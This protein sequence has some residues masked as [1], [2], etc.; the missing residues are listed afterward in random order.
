VT[1]DPSV[2]QAS[3]E[4]QTANEGL[5]AELRRDALVEGA[6]GKS[7]TFCGRDG[8]VKA[9]PGLEIGS[10]WCAVCEDHFVRSP[11]WPPSLS[12]PSAQ[13]GTVSLEALEQLLKRHAL[14]PA[15]VAAKGETVAKYAERWLKSR[16]TK[17]NSIRDDRSRLRDHVLPVV[18][19]LD[20]ATFGRDDVENVRDALDAK[21]ATGALSW[22]T[23]RNVWGTFTK[24]CDDA[25]NVKARALRVRKDNPALGVKPPE[26][27]RVK[28][29]Q[30]LYPSECL[31]LVSCED[32]PFSWRRNA[33]VAIYSYLRDGEL[34]ELRWEDVD[35]EHATIAVSHAYNRRKKAS[36]VPKTQAGTRRVPIEPTLLPLLRAMHDECGGEGLVVRLPSERT[37]ARSLR[38][39][40]RRAGVTRDALYEASATSK[41]CGWHD[42][43]AT[44]ITWLAVR[45]LDLAKIQAR[46][47]HEDI[48]TTLGYVRLAEAVGGEAFGVA[49]P[50][51]P[52]SLLGGGGG[53][54]SEAG[55]PGGGSGQVRVPSTPPEFPPE[56]ASLGGL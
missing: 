48:E 26:R 38:R 22:K 4:R 52:E 25:V 36:G 27:G 9:V 33:A 50:P 24:L 35:L 13:P 44:G 41:P 19:V 23:A 21:I 47:G 37:M 2:P 5:L 8:V 12:A 40:L 49:F 54:G 51:L 31:T 3:S 1:F 46:A 16:E 28:A 17:V 14:A 43:R 7:C 6:W 34:R 53:N 32:V 18:G 56:D 15:K 39:W 30:F 55:G 42:L 10:F 11:D 45:G 29:K 20:V